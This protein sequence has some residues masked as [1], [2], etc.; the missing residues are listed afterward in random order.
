MT[1]QKQKVSVCPACGSRNYEYNEQGKY[2]KCK[3]CNFVWDESFEINA[4]QRINEANKRIILNDDE[5]D[6]ELS[7]EDSEGDG[8]MGGAGIM[9][10]PED[11]DEE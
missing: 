11:F 10:P 3:R 7:H 8:L 1:K 5:E 9:F 6:D 4:N 2:Y